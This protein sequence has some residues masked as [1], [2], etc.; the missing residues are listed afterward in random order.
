M[1]VYIYNYASGHWKLVTHCA[2]HSISASLEI[3]SSNFQGPASVLC[4]SIVC[5]VLNAV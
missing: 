5:G 4:L 1:C 3:L 2:M